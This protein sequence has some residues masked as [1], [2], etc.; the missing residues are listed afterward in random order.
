[1]MIDFHLHLGKSSSGTMYTV[2]D[3]ISMLDEYDIKSAGLSML[4]GTDVTKLNNQV[5]EH[6]KKYPERIVPFAYINP[7][8]ENAIEEVDRTLGTLKMKGIKFHSWKHGYNPENSNSLDDVV[9]A[10]GKYD[11]PILTHTG[12]APLSLPQSWARVAEKFPM[13]KW[14][15]A[16]IGLLDYGYGCVEAV[17]DLENI[18]VDTSGQNEVQILEKAFEEL[19]EDR[20]IYAS[21]WPYKHVGSE[22]LKLDC[23][24]MTEEQKIKVFHNNSAKLLGLELI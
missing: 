18:W 10:I 21:D 9:R 19:G 23:L 16:H 4:N 22:I 15:F 6:Y 3:L 13:Q 8:D 24:N 20:I 1:M 11:V 7:R 2:E 17:K 12:T 14:V 5:Y